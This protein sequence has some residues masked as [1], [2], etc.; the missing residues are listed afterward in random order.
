M[1]VTPIVLKSKTLP[2][3]IAEVNEQM[4]LAA[5][6][7][8]VN[9]LVLQFP[10][11]SMLNAVARVFTATKSWNATVDSSN[12]YICTFSVVKYS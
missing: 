6:S 4:K 12:P 3:L 11:T 1:A 5:K 2:E 9:G 7:G 10:F 8:P